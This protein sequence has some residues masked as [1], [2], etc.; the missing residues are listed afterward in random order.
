VKRISF[1]LAAL[2]MTTAAWADRP[3]QSD[4]AS[5]IDQ[6]ACEAEA[7]IGNI[8]DSGVSVDSAELLGGCGIG[9][10]TQLG[11]SYA[12]L[13]GGGITVQ[14]LGLNG[15]TILGASGA[16]SFGVNYG[17]GF[18]KVPGSSFEFDTVGLT[19]IASHKISSDWLVHANLGITRSRLADDSFTNWSI[20]FERPGNLT[21]AVDLYGGEGIS[22]VS[23]GVGYRF[24]KA[25]SANL[26]LARQIGGTGSA[27]EI[28][29][30][31][32]L[33]F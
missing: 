1:A 31:L 8:K 6:G 15:K 16:T 3:L 13:S 23:G 7:V 5:V 2:A 12:R 26:V 18:S 9:R 29:A 17:L 21:W 14:A 33:D 28:S 32:K 24:S 22:F 25:A 19:G 30:G 11:I 27:R 10:K 4:F 20:G